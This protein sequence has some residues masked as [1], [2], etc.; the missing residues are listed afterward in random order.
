MKDET[1]FLD[2]GLG[3][4]NEHTP[5]MFKNY[6]SFRM[7]RDME[8]EM[9]RVQAKRFRRIDDKITDYKSSPK[10]NQIKDIRDKAMTMIVWAGNLRC[11]RMVDDAA[12]YIR[13]MLYML[14]EMIDELIEEPNDRG[15]LE[16]RIEQSF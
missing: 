8:E 4:F 13:D 6:S 2:D 12:S 5:T 1:N 9:K 10:G 14:K 3:N 16:Y 7:L 15:Y 11:K